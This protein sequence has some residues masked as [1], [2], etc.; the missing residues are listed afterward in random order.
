MFTV[1][2]G[3]ITL[4]SGLMVFRSV[5]RCIR[6]YSIAHLRGPKPDS[7]L[8]GS[9]PAL[10]RPREVGDADFAW[11]KEFGNTLTMK[12][13]MGKDILMTADPKAC[14]TLF[15]LQYILNT[16]GYNFPKTL[17]V[18]RQATLTTGHGIVWAEGTQHAR[19]RKIMNPAFSFGA[20]RIFLPLFRHT[21]QRMV[22]SLEAELSKSNRT[23]SVFDIM[24]WLS[25]TTLDAIGVAGFDYQFGAIE[26]GH[27]NKLAQAYDNLFVDTWMERPDSMLVWGDA[28]DWVP[29][30]MAALLLNL[31][32]ASLKRLHSYMEIA[33][34]VAKDIVDRQKAIHASGKEGS[35]D[36]MSI[37]VR[38]NLAENPKDRLSE[39]EVLSQLTTLFLAGHETT[40]TS[41]TWAI[42]ELARNPQYQTLVRDEIKVTRNQATQRG[43]DELSVAD[44]DSM[45]YL[46]SL[47]KETLRFHPIVPMILRK[48]K[49]D[50]V[51]PLST[52][53]T[54]KK[55]EVITN[56][57]IPAGQ[58]IIISISAYNRLKSVWGDDADVWR[59]E[60]FIDGS[61]KQGTNLGVYAN[62]ASFSSGVR[63]CIGWRFAVI[64]MQ[65]ILIELLEKF[66]FSPPPG[67]V[68]ILRG[69][70]GVLTPM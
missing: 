29:Q 27:T 43:D 32:S 2:V 12:G 40:A 18:R 61:V 36:I 44:L 69:S 42:Y 5:F 60:R 50:D 9:L 63:G 64:E 3:A 41:L 45:K 16:S 22:V 65:A 39:V 28:L 37:L 46:L 6:S 47:M 56:V 38:A 10:T 11:T 24:P 68:K 67:D 57:A 1:Y 4:L 58:K 7:W 52:P 33:L 15:A 17:A 54:T 49:R 62:L 23:S 31:P 70:A 48:S 35:K 26:Q 30:W 51:I 8:V 19:H 66:E 21:S 55:G 59:P 34:G 20:L 53:I 25:R 13:V 14:M